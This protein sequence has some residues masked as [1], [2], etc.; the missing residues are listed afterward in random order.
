M[1]FSIARSLTSTSLQDG[2]P[3]VPHGGRFVHRR[4]PTCVPIAVK[5]DVRADSGAKANARPF[6][7]P[8]RQAD[9]LVVP[10]SPPVKLAE[11]CCPGGEMVALS[12]QGDEHARETGELIRTPHR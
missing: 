1:G 5:V 6:T 2:R 8:V 3:E 11:G 9:A 10:Q 7:Q 4:P 12:I